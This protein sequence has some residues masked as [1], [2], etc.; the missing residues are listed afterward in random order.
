MVLFLAFLIG[1]VSGLRAM[2][3]LAAVSWAARLGW[4]NLGDTKLAF[5]GY[6]FTPYIVTLLAL[7]ELV[8]DQ[9]P[10]TPSRL[11]PPQFATRVVMGAFTGAAVGAA[12][13]MLVAGLVAGIVGAV[14]GTL[15]GARLRGAMAKAFGSDRPAALVEDLIAIGLAF[16]IV[17]R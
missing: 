6:R 3:G 9:L 13:H 1:V 11:V 4:L 14:V 7:A 15:G 17:S 16:F 8:T 2:M 12:S 10:S 5:L